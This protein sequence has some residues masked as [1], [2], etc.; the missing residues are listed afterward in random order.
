MTIHRCGMI[1]SR[2]LVVVCLS[3]LFYALAPLHLL[4]NTF[5][6]RINVFS[7]VV[8]KTIRSPCPPLPGDGHAYQSADAEGRASS[9]QAEE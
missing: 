8:E 3:W 2:T 5:P 9:E 6:S 4:F 7:E 1:L